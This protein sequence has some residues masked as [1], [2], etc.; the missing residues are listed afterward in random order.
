MQL[1]QRDELQATGITPG[2][3]LLDVVAILC[4]QIRLHKVVD[5][6]CDFV[7]H[8]DACFEQNGDFENH[9]GLSNRPSFSL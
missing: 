4:G 8:R 9:A 7:V 5:V 6:S 1:M 3:F 2:K